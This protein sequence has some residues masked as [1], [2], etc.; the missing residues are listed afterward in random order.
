MTPETFAAAERILSVLTAG[1]FGYL[2][3]RLYVL[4]VTKGPSKLQA[5][6]QW[7]EFVMSGTGPGIVF[8]AFGGAVLIYAL[9]TSGIRSRMIEQVSTVAPRAES[10]ARAEPA[11]SMARLGN[12]PTTR[13]YEF[14]SSAPAR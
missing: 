11:A 1:F 12:P 4:G 10:A 13:T 2:G 9:A 7:G 6:S 3:F 5:K 8:M 14:A